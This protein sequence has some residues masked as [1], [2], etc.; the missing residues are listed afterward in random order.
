MMIYYQLAP[1]NRHDPIFSYNMNKTSAFEFPQN[2]NSGNI[3][4]ILNKVFNAI[5]NN[6]YVWLSV[7]FVEE[8]EVHG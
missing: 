2:L 7:L 8:T 4:C 1:R 6:I 3:L 5:F